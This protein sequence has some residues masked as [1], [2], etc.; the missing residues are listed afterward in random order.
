MGTF[1]VPNII[2]HLLFWG[3]QKRTLI[4]TT[5]C[6]FQDKVVFGTLRDTLLV[7]PSKV[8][9]RVQVPSDHIFSGILTY[10][11]IILKPS[12]YSR[13]QEVGTSLSSCP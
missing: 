1:W 3:T 8:S 2:R 10:I 4:L 6:I 13:S 9:L 12:T 7:L 11:A 5:T